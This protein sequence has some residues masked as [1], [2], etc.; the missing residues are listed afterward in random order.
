MPTGKTSSYILVSGFKKKN[1]GNNG[2]HFTLMTLVTLK[3]LCSYNSGKNR[4]TATSNGANASD[5]K[6]R[7]VNTTFCRYRIFH[8][9]SRKISE[10]LQTAVKSTDGSGL[11]LIG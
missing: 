1:L 6:E 5:A 10:L 2:E 11:F 7:E 8:F 4:V 9:S 3:V